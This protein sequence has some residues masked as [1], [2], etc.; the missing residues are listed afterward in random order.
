MLFGVIPVRFP[1]V[2]VENGAEGG[3]AV[4]SSD[5][6]FGTGLFEP[7]ANQVF[8][9]TCC[10]A[11]AHCCYASMKTNDFIR[12]FPKIPNFIPFFHA[13]VPWR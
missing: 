4:D 8:T 10:C 3:H 1:W 5:S 2:A 11:G 9:R 13:S 6:P 7:L 12:N